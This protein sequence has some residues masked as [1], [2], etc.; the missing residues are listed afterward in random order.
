MSDQLG[1]QP[2]YSPARTGTSPYRFT[3]TPEQSAKSRAR[4]SFLTLVFACMCLFATTIETLLQEHYTHRIYPVYVFN[5]ITSTL[6][7]LLT[8]IGRIRDRTILSLGLLYEILMC[9]SVSMG[10][11]WEE[12]QNSGALPGVTWV[13]IVIVSYPMIIPSPPRR[14]F[15]A[16]LVAASMVPL[17]LFLLQSRGL[18]TPR[19]FDY[20]DT[21]IS[22]LFCV[23]FAVLG[24]R[25]IYGLNVDVARARQM[26]AYQLEELIGKGGMGEV[27][28][29]THRLLARPAALK[30]VKPA[31]TGSRLPAENERLL[32]RFKREAQVT[33]GLESPY[34]VDLYDYGVTDGGVF[35]YV[36]ELLDGLDLESLVRKYG[37][38]SCARAAHIMYQACHSLRE[39]HAQG[40]VHRDIKPANIVVC[41]SR[42]GDFDFTKVLDFGLVALRSETG[43]DAERLTAV[44]Q[45]GGTPAYMAPETLTEDNPDARADI[46]ALG[47]VAYWLLT[48][49]LVFEHDTP[50]N[51]ALAHVREDPVPPSKRTEI[52]IPSEFEQ[53]ILSCLEKDPDKRPQST[54]DLTESLDTLGLTLEWTQKRAEEWWELHKPLAA[55]PTQSGL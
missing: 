40:L 4:L 33:A 12:Y 45:V 1:L 38:V 24:S 28:R 9:L 50:M 34:T 39:A 41:R 36:M 19:P 52:E 13:C 43:A 2:H 49:R 31:A 17:G 25:V 55:G 15:F 3:L 22:P 37:P 53:L 42:A 51:I 20:V 47:C 46:Y 48:G 8:R 16:S 11:T 14:T 30:L 23:V 6:L 5:F 32:K 27:W 35:Y 10:F 21:L 29:A 54:T 18:V 7:F 26:G 44:G